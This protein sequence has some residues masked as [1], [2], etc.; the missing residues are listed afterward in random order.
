MYIDFITAHYSHGAHAPQQP[1]QNLSQTSH[2][3]HQ[4]QEKTHL[5]ISR[6]EDKWS[7]SLILLIAHF[8]YIYNEL[9]NQL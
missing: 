2:T 4:Q 9:A 5:A 1:R 7:N 8:Y 3:T 6:K